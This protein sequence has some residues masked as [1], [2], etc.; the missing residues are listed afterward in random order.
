MQ[1]EM[2]QIHTHHPIPLSTLVSLSSL[3]PIP[4]NEDLNTQLYPGLNQLQVLVRVTT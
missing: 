2:R 3:L 4:W 1:V